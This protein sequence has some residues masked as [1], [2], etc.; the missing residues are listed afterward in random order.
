MD[1]VCENDVTA[2]IEIL[3]LGWSI[4]SIR[5]QL[6]FLQSGHFTLLNRFLLQNLFVASSSESVGVEN[7]KAWVPRVRR[8]NLRYRLSRMLGQYKTWREIYTSFT[9]G[10]GRG[11]ERKES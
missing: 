6:S 5:S 11:N 9:T 3:Y 2:K 7:M 8:L 4:Q 1:A 10:R